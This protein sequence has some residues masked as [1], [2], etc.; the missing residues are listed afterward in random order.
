MKFAKSIG[1]WKFQNEN[2]WNLIA[3][4]YSPWKSMYTKYNSFFKILMGTWQKI[5]FLLKK[6]NKRTITRFSLVFLIFDRL[7]VKISKKEEHFSFILFHEESES[8][9]RFQKF[10]F[11]NFH[12]PILLAN[13]TVRNP[14]QEFWKLFFSFYNMIADKVCNNMALSYVF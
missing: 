10:S 6:T 5:R 11:W 1:K 9:I 12:F 4:S 2:F 7:L 13:F 8:A 14:S 3:D